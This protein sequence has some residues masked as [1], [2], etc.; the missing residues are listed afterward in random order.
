MNTRGWCPTV[1][2][3]MQTGDGLLARLI[4]HEPIAI[5][6]LSA[7]CLAAE[8][9]GNGV[10]E[11]TQRGSL[12]IRGLSEVS[13]PMFAHAV[14]SL[15]V[16]MGGGPPLLTSPLLGL[17]V[18]EPFHS[19]VVAVSLLSLLN[20]GLQGTESLGPKVSVLIDGGGK[21][22]LD[23]VTA[24]IRLVAACDSLLQLSLA[25]NAQNALHLGYVAMDR[26]AATVDVLLRILATI[27]STARARDLV[28][29]PVI[30]EVR[31]SLDVEGNLVNDLPPSGRCHSARAPAEPIGTHELKDGTVALGFALPFG[32]TTA[33][34]L[35]H[36]AEAAADYGASCI[37]PAPGRALLAIGLSQPDANKL[38]DV[39]TAEDFVVDHRDA[40]RHVITCAGA[41]ACAAAKLATR[42][43]AAD[44]ASATQRLAG[45]SKIVHLAG[46]SKGC[47]H[48]GP[49]ALTIVGP[50]RVVLNGRASDTPHAMISSA[51]LIQDITRLCSEL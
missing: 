47:A 14:A 31:Q 51:G 18:Y 42:Q 50:D 26:V 28:C 25:G 15:E 3:P 34:T 2:T 12:Q 9:H 35:R 10:I 23:A 7:L 43:L 16:G 27:G 45:S 5:S 33:T 48:P 30:Q 11:V 8:E 44:V 20:A 36:V 38:R 13:A 17:D 39:A 41:P 40:R 24:D 1:S 4:L 37:R 21:L 19:S 32:Y 49:A 46:C 6:K 22:H 29:Q